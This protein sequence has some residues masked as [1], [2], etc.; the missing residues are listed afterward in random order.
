NAS[1]HLPAKADQIEPGTNLGLR[2][3]DPFEQQPMR[4]VQ[5]KQRPRDGIGHQPGLIG[6]NATA[7]TIRDSAAFRSPPTARRRDRSEISASRGG[8]PMTTGRRAG[9]AMVA[10]MKQV[11]RRPEADGRL[12]PATRA[13]KA[14]GADN[15]LR[16]LSIIFQRS[17]TG[18]ADNAGPTFTDRLRPKIQGNNCQSPRTHRCLRAAATSYRE[19]NSS[20]TSISDTNPARAKVPSNRS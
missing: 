19:G 9:T 20:T 3:S 10:R 16:R 5:A 1:R 17:I 12:H 14:A 18:I 11:H 4:Y 7:S 2:R 8:M 15:D 6:Q 13:T